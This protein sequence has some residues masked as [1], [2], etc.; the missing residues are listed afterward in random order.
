MK[1]RLPYGL[2]LFL[3]LTTLLIPSPALA[4]SCAW[5]GTPQE[6]FQT[7]DAV[8]LGQVT[9]YGFGTRLSDFLRQNTPFPDRF[10]SLHRTYTIS[11]LQSWKGVDV[12]RITI[13]SDL[14]GCG[15][16]LI[17]GEKVIF[18]AG[19]SGGDLF[20]SQCSRTTW[21]DSSLAPEDL[22]YLNTLPTLPLKSAIFTYLPSL[23]F[24][25]LLVAF[26][27]L[28]ILNKNRKRNQSSIPNN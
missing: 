27:V 28:L 3:V 18:Y 13:H 26:T 23:L 1:K 21:A 10:L 12:D 16:P 19:Q 11:V 5:P 20:V 2:A 24:M 25:G 6:E 9:G 7:T 15:Y 22:A 14:D 4:C 8:F 17:P